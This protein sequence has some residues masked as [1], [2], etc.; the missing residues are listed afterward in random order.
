MAIDPSGALV[1]STSNAVYRLDQIGTRTIVA[2]PRFGFSGDGGPATAAA[3]S[4]IQG[5]AFNTS[6]NLFI[7]DTG[8][9][10]VRRVIGS[11][12]DTVAVLSD[13]PVSIA[14]DRA[15]QI[16][17]TGMNVVQLL[18]TE[19]PTIVAGGGTVD[20]DG[21]PAKQVALGTLGGIVAD[22]MGNVY[23]SGPAGVRMLTPSPTDSDGCLY[24]VRFLNLHS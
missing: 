6:G 17:V 3:F 24:N 20:A 15:G 12:V 23:V 2:G 7:A 8:N 18:S 11:T 19:G 5:L 21:G 1:F 13:A 9:K 14:L 4:N 10:R 16:Y 22:A